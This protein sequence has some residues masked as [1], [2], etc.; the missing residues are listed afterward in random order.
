MNVLFVHQNFPG[1]FLHLAPALARRGHNVLALTA[2]ANQR[3]APVRTLRYRAPVLPVVEGFGRTYAEMTE[4]GAVVARG[5]S[6]ITAREGFVP[7][8]IIG[9]SGWGETLF[10]RQVYPDAKIL[11]YAE[12]L[13][14]ATG[15]DTNFDPEFPRPALQSAIAVTARSAHLLQAMLD[16][17]AAIAPTVW[18]ASTFPPLLRQKIRVIHDGIDTRRVCPDPAA[19]LTLPS[20]QVLRAGDPV[21]SFV[22]RNLEPYRGYHT[23]MRALPEVLAACPEAQVVIVGGEGQSYGAA[24][25]QGTWKQIFLAEVADRIDPAR[26]HFLGRV[27]YAQFLSLLQITRAHAYLTYPFVLSWSMLEAMAAGALVIGSRTPPVQ[28]V[29][30]DG[31]NGRLVDFFDVKGWSAALIRAMADPR[32]DDPLRRAA[33]DTVVAR[34]D[35]QG[36]CLPLMIAYVESLGAARAQDGSGFQ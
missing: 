15:L 11:T 4:R 32:A 29:I 6:Q 3:P 10:L 27:P 13:Y 8:L 23:F 1:Q 16:T 28:E 19:T 25:Q 14:R 33:R 2:E 12:F 17:D 18:Q 7:D 5:C 34:Y 36:I 22:N 21:I 31:Q 9:H 30:T 24:P 26:V 20:G 35:L